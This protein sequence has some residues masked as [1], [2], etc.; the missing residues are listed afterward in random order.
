VVG[1]HVADL[2]EPF[3]FLRSTTAPVV[4]PVSAFF[5]PS[6]GRN[7]AV[8]TFEH[9]IATVRKSREAI[10]RLSA[11]LERGEANDLARRFAEDGLVRLIGTFQRFAEALYAELP[12]VA[13]ARRNVF[14]TVAE[15]S[16]LW[17][18]ALGRSYPDILSSTQLQTLTRYVQ[19]R[20]LLAHCEA[21]VDQNYLDRSGDPTYRLGQRVIV[22]ADDIRA[23]ANLLTELARGLRALVATRGL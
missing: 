17:S 8:S 22:R 4:G 12:Q 9:T 3:Q 5:C 6:C 18:A 10:P 13:P 19:Q 2:P 21:I 11:M 1:V 20:H 23:P 7:S 16:E 14:Q 15:A